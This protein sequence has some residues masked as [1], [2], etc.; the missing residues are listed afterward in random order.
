MEKVETKLY[1]QIYHRIPTGYHADYYICSL[2]RG[3]MLFEEN[4]FIKP[5]ILNLKAKRSQVDMNAQV[6][7]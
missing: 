1:E 6:N 5:R 7:K 3:L 4:T 2:V